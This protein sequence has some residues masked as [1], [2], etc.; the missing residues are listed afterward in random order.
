[1]GRG[2][3]GLLIACYESGRKRRVASGSDCP[4]PIPFSLYLSLSLSSSLSF[5]LSFSPFLSL[6]LSVR[7]LSAGAFTYCYLTPAR[8]VLQTGGCG[9]SVGPAAPCALRPSLVRLL[10]WLA[11]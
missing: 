10:G 7:L 11:E 4:T 6:P 2:E 5:S 1:M 9:V 3:G 8:P